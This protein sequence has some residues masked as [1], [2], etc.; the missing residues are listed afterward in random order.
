[1]FKNIFILIITIILFSG[2]SRLYPIATAVVAIPAVIIS[3]GF[4]RSHHHGYFQGHRGRH[5]HR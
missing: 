1:M 3:P 2:C 4:H 5:R